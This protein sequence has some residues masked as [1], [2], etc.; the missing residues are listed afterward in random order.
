MFLFVLYIILV[1]FSSI[2]KLALLDVEH[3]KPTMII[4]IVPIFRSCLQFC[5]DFSQFGLISPQKAK[6]VD[7]HDTFSRLN[8]G[9]KNQNC[10]L[11]NNNSTSIPFFPSVSINSKEPMKMNEHE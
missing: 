11:I 7:T 6:I 5:F 3:K 4:C 9:H 8:V 10:C 1:H 2:F